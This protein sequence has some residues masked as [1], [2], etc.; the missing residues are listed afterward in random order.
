MAANF[1]C[2][3][4]NARPIYRQKRAL[5]HGQGRKLGELTFTIYWPVFFK[6]QYDFTYNSEGRLCTHYTRH[7]TQSSYSES[8]LSK[9]SSTYEYYH[10]GNTVEE[11]TFYVVFKGNTRIQGS[12][13]IQLGASDICFK[14]IAK[15]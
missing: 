12:A 7:M 11:N 15:A 13:Q 6:T 4:S 3:P 1:P 14:N 8:E 5:N 10:E 2:C 9:N